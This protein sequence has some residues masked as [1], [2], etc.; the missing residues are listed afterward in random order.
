MPKRL[1]GEVRRYQECGQ[2]RYGFV[3]VRCEECRA[4]TLVAFSCKGR[5]HGGL[6]PAT[7]R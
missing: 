4:L 5:G 1:H 2:L 6:P 7:L 3:E